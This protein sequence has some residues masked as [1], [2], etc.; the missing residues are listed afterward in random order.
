MKADGLVGTVRRISAKGR[1]ISWAPG[2]RESNASIQCGGYFNR[3]DRP[4][5]FDCEAFLRVGRARRKTRS[6]RGATL[7]ALRTWDHGGPVVAPEPIRIPLCKMLLVREG[8]EHHF[9]YRSD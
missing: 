2:V 4:C 5:V 8:T 6:L 7:P 1:E 3:T 9:D